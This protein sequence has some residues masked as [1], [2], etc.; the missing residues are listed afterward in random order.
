MYSILT[1]EKYIC[2]EWKEKIVNS[3][4]KC[5]MCKSVNIPSS[6][7]CYFSFLDQNACVYMKEKFPEDLE[8]IQRLFRTVVFKGR[9]N[10][11][12]NC[13]STL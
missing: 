3:L 1:C 6:L 11:S 13:K 5:S 9:R 7:L 8:D 12:L 4:T 10:V 2:Y